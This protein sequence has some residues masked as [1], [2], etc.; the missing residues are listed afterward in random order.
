[1]KPTFFK[2]LKIWDEANPTTPLSKEKGG[3]GGACY[4]FFFLINDSG[5]CVTN[6]EAVELFRKYQIENKGSFIYDGIRDIFGKEFW[7]SS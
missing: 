3:G 5:E 2:N 7:F 6:A 1:M 4:A